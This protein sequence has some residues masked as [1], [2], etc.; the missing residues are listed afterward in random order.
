VLVAASFVIPVAEGFLKGVKVHLEVV[1][2]VKALEEGIEAPLV[3]VQMA[4]AAWM[5]VILR[6]QEQHYRQQQV[7][8]LLY[9]A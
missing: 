8:F 6:V 5:M 2:E 3:V 7:P 1:W 9:Q 4:E